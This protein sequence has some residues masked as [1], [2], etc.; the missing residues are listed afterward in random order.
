MVLKTELIE[1]LIAIQD[2]IIA[3]KMNNYSSK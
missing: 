3:D 2:N 1:T